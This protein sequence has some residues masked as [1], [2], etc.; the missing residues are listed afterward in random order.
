MLA[1]TADEQKAQRLRNLRTALI[2]GSIAVAGFVGVIL[3]TWVT[4]K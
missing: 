1:M 3:R 4:M 2:F